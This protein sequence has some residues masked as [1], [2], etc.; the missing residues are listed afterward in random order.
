MLPDQLDN[1][2]VR[3]QALTEKQSAQWEAKCTRCGSCCGVAEN[4]PCENLIALEN[5][6]YAC[7]V[8]ENRF[9]P[10]RT[11]G[12]RVFQCVPL[13]WIINQHWPGDYLCGYKKKSH[14]E[15]I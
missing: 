12:G 8:Y 9:G 13:R 11:V 2:D 10:Q 7:R 6:T 15:I 14:D 3:Y 1:D 5:N 4:D